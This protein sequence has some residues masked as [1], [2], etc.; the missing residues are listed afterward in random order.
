MDEKEY[1]SELVG[2][3]D[4]RSLIP[5]RQVPVRRYSQGLTASNLQEIKMESNIEQFDLALSIKEK[6][7]VLS[8]D[9]ALIDDSMQ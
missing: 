8:L 4:E 7:H 6:S 9:M 1:K 5:I 2:N 3:S